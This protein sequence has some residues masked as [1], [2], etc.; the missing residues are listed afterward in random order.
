MKRYVC[1]SCGTLVHK[2]KSFT[3]GHF[4]LELVLWCCFLLPGFIYSIWRVC[5]RHK[6]CPAC[7]SNHLL[8][9]QS[10]V[11]QDLLRRRLTVNPS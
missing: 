10:P 9:E 1:G 11:A 8:P 7:Y 3:P 2:P 5:R 4:L 6:V